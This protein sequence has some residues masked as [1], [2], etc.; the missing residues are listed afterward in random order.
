MSPGSLAA[1]G[2]CGRQS[3]GSA[4]PTSQ[5]PGPRH[6]LA[7]SWPLMVPLFLGSG[8]WGTACPGLYGDP[9]EPRVHGLGWEGGGLGVLR[10]VCPGAG[11]ARS[12]GSQE[13][14]CG[15]LT[16]RRRSCFG[17]PPVPRGKEQHTGPLGSRPGPRGPPGQRAG[18]AGPGLCG[19]EGL[20]SSAAAP[21]GAVYGTMPS[22]PLSTP[23]PREMSRFPSMWLQEQ[24]GA[25]G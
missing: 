15:A 16:G 6:P 24:A 2:H 8:A 20:H 10:V 1:L 17:Y 23:S 25:E 21:G 13:A 11:W 7:G 14:G 18:D 9:P 5:A 19:Q 22:S 3:V 12:P 4:A